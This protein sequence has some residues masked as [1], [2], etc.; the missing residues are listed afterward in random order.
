MASLTEGGSLFPPWA[1]GGCGSCTAETPQPYHSGDG[2]DLTVAPA[3]NSSVPLLRVVTL[4]LALLDPGCPM[5]PGAPRASGLPGAEP[6][7]LR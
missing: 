7:S 5:A 6:P 2:T 1:L 3:L 4:P